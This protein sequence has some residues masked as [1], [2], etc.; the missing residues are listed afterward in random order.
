LATNAFV[1]STRVAAE[2]PQQDLE[3]DRK[4]STKEAS[5]WAVSKQIP[6]METSAKVSAVLHVTIAFVTQPQTNTNVSNSFETLLRQIVA[7]APAEK[8]AEPTSQKPGC[9][10]IM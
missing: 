1:L 10:T 7:M 2:S 3:S 8:A 9:C 6:F 5:D 4:V